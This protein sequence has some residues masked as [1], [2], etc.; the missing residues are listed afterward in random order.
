[1]PDYAR[2]GRLPDLAGLAGRGFPYDG[3][4]GSTALVVDSADA[5]AVSAA[6]TL[7]AKLAVLSHYEVSIQAGLVLRGLD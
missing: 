6:A 4:G 3:P 1:M 5:D 7:L 2:I